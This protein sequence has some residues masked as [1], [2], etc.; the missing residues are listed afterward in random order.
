M[1]FEKK[2]VISSS[3]FDKNLVCHEGQIKNHWAKF[4]KKFLVQDARITK[5]KIEAIFD[6]KTL[7]MSH[8]KILLKPLKTDQ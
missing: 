4:V 7:K 8:K 2:L 6:L 5:N 1:I 3:E